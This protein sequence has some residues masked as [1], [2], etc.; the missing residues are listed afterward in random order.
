MPHGRKI[1]FAAARWTIPAERMKA[2][3]SHVV[4]LSDQEVGTTPCFCS[5]T[6][7]VGPA[8]PQRRGI[9]LPRC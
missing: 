9:C 5:I 1:D 6:L 7:L 4:P 8:S 2:G 3:K